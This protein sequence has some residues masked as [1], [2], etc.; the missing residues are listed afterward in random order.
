MAMATPLPISIFFP[1]LIAPCD[2]STG[3]TSGA[4]L[5]LRPEFCGVTGHTPS[6]TVMR[7]QKFLRNQSS[8]NHRAGGRT[9]DQTRLDITERE[10]ATACVDNRSI[11]AG[12]GQKSKKLSGR[13]TRVRREWELGPPDATFYNLYNWLEGRVGLALTALKS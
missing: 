11:I 6:D 5:P 4:A 12:A 2:I 8:A 10:S 9:A 1:V 13:V 3:A 7:A